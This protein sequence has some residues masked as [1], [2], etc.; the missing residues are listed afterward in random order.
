[1][2]NPLPT[3]HLLCGK[4][5]AGKSTLAVRRWMRT[6][7]DGSGAAHE[8]H[9]LDVPNETCRR[10]LRARNAAGGHPYPTSDADYELFTRYFVSPT[11]DEK[12]NVV[13]HKEDS[14]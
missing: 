1:M 8:L 12:F 2:S 9:F 10:R 5:A 7:I 11:P 14:A 3:L 6:L 4:I 13:V